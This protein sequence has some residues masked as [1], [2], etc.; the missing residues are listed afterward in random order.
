MVVCINLDSAS[1]LAQASKLLERI[2][3]H[4]Q[5]QV[6]LQ[7]KHE[8]GAGQIKSCTLKVFMLDAFIFLC[9]VHVCVLRLS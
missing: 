2:E 4:I 9:H 8:K 7:D 6:V 1:E 3:R 5:A